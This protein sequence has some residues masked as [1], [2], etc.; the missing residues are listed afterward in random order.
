[1][2][3]IVLVTIEQFERA[4]AAAVLYAF[5]SPE[6]PRSVPPK[7]LTI[8]NSVLVTSK[9]SSC[10]NIGIPAVYVGSP[11]SLARVLI[12]SVPRRQAKQ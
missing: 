8:T 11:S 7:Y 9:L 6:V 2:T 10:L 4:S 3:S 12:C 5:M 1:M